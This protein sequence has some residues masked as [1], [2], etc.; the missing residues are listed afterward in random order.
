MFCVL[1]SVC[2]NTGSVKMVWREAAGVCATKV[3]KDLPVLEVSCTDAD[4]Q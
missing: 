2:V 1:Q 4:V 3:G